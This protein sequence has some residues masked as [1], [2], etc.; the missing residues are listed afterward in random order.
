MAQQ[1]LRTVLH[2][3]RK[4]LENRFLV[5][6]DDRLSLNPQVQVDTRE[7]EAGLRLPSPDISTLTALLQLY[8]GDFLDGF[9]LPDASSFDDWAAVEREHYRTLAIRAYTKLSG[10]YESQRDHASALD[11]LERALAF[12]P[13]QEDLQREAL[14]L[15]FLSGDRAGAVRRYEALCKLLSEEMGIPPMPETRAVYDAIISDTLPRSPDTS[16]R[17]AQPVTLS[18]RQPSAEPLMPFT[19][20]SIELDML[21]TLSLSRK[22]VLLEGAPGIGKT[23]LVN[24]FLAGLKKSSRSAGSAA[25]VLQGVAHESELGLPYQPIVDALRSLLF[26]DDWPAVRAN[27]DLAPV[28]LAEILR[29]VPDLQRQLPDLPLPAEINDEARLWEGVHQFLQSISLRRQVI[30]FLD[31]LHWADTSTLGLTGYLAR[32]LTSSALLLIGTARPVDSHS[33]LGLLWKDL[34]YE[35]HL[36]VIRIAPLSEADTLAVAGQ[37]SPISPGPFS[38]WLLDTAEGNP[39]LLTE[40]VR[41]A[42]TINLLH[43]D[44]TLDTDAFTISQALPPTIQNLIL[45]RLIRLSENARHVLDV[46]A[47]V[48]REFDFELLYRTMALSEIAPSE[49]V[50]LDALDELQTAVLIQPRGSENYSFDHSLTM[51]VV[52]QDMSQPRQRRLHRQVAQAMEQ[53]HPDRSGAIAGLIARHYA[54]SN[55]PERV[56]SY[57]F[58]AGR[59]AAS[60]AAWEEAIAFYDQAIPVEQDIHQ[61]VAILLALG[62]ARF[63]KGDFPQAS[64]TFLTALNLARSSSDLT[65]LELA[66]L[67]LNKS[68]L[69]QSRYAEAIALGRELAQTGPPEL[70][71]CAQF[72]WGAGLSVESAQPVEAETHLRLAEKLLSEQPEYTG[73]IT[74]ALLRYQLAA[75]VG[76]Q[77][78][79]AEAVTFYREALASLQA[80]E[81]SLDLLRQIMLYNNLA[82]HLSLLGD[83]AAAGF[84]ETGMKLAQERGSLTH[85]PYLLSTSGE[86]ALGRDDL[87]AAEEFFTRGLKLAEQVPVPE[88]IAGLTANLGLVARRR[89]QDELARQRLTVALELAT[90]LGVLHLVVRIRCWLAPLLQPAE[91]RT[92]LQEAR[93]LAEKSGFGNLLEEIASLENEL[94]TT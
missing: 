77:G 34:S 52:L 47:V 13:L 43:P 56:A 64:D 69:P 5:V 66:Y 23:R 73:P 45:S 41:H 3:I 40:L 32:R 16:S 57:A 30:L 28:W 83:P 15:D 39:Y 87:D 19:G 91:A 50:V 20:R 9:T 59:Y 17:E 90:Q 10:L 25:L 11:A 44:G 49:E 26:H 1:T 84:A 53:L 37:L 94:L 29:L 38:R 86:I 22:L 24:E 88:R 54:R 61:R 72:I 31:D 74:R 82:Y 68:L 27:L 93:Q 71:I 35:D 80:N 89:G 48:G 78:K 21:R 18:L 8:R 79:S 92:Q 6:E 75:V 14:R 7:F 65:H 81:V 70:A 46:A 62:D 76:Q 4:H 42:Y 58:Q 51:E 2:D 63:H 33:R 12:D 60:L 55:T 85:L 36:A 67:E